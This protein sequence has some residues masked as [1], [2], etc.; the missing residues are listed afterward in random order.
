MI[1]TTF[2]DRVDKDSKKNKVIPKGYRN[3]FISC[4]LRATNQ[5]KD[6]DTVAYL[7]N[8]HS[9]PIIIKFL[10]SKGATINEDIYSLSELI[11]FVWRSAIRDNK[12]INLYIPSERMRNIF[13]AW[14]NNE[15]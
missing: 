6:R 1:W 9:D 12:P 7:I 14:L 15:I 8:K 10:N 4:N 11:Q 2:K 5:Y 13:K 3:A